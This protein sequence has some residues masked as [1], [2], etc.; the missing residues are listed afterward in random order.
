MNILPACM[1]VYH[2]YA[3]C[4]WRPKEDVGIHG[5]GV[6]DGVVI[7]WVLRTEPRSFARAASTFNY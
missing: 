5:T 6:T 3:W 2:M 1:D 7:M 4:L